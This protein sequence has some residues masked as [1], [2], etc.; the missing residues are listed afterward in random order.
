[1]CF[2]VLN[3]H[4]DLL[5]P[6]SMRAK[7]SFHFNSI[8]GKT[9][10]RHVSWRARARMCSWGGGKS[11]LGGMVQSQTV[12]HILYN[13]F[14]IACE[15]TEYMKSA[16]VP[17][18]MSTAKQFRNSCCESLTVCARVLRDARLAGAPVCVR[19]RQYGRHERASEHAECRNP[20]RVFSFLFPARHPVCSAVVAAGLALCVCVCVCL[21]IESVYTRAYIPTRIHT[22]IQ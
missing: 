20:Y 9:P 18:T 2:G 7:R 17:F 21:L 19:A 16:F 15:S 6:P 8:V 12:L 4:S 3:A 10:R 14:N 5:H 22:R 1:M 11:G 13:L